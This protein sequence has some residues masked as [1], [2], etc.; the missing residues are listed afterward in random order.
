MGTN[1]STA[2]SQNEEKLSLHDHAI[3]LSLTNDNLPLFSHWA[4]VT[5]NVKTL[6][7]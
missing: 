4:N 2:L 5:K 3:R 7:E 6:R 1:N